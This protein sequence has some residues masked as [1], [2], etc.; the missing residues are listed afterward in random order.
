MRNRLALLVLWLAVPAGPALA[1]DVLPI[2]PQRRSFTPDEL[3]AALRAGGGPAAG[4]PL[5]DLAANAGLLQKIAQSPALRK[6][7]ENLMGNEELRNRLL[8]DPEL[9][10]KFD[11]PQLRAMAERLARQLPKPPPRTGDSPPAGIPP[12]L[13]RPPRPDAP[14]PPA[15]AE[16][17]V[18]GQPPGADPDPVREM[19]EG[20]DPE[21][22]RQELRGL[23]RDEPAP[24][25]GLPEGLSP[26]DPSPAPGG[27]AAADDR[28]GTAANRPPPVRTEAD[29]E[30]ARQRVRQ[31]IRQRRAQ[32]DGDPVQ[33]QAALNDTLNDL[34]GRNANRPERRTDPSR[35][36]EG[37]TRRRGPAAVTPDR[38]DPDGPKPERPEFGRPE[39]NGPVRNMAPVADTGPTGRPRTPA[40]TTEPPAPVPTAG[41][42]TPAAP[43]A[44][45][46]LRTAA[47]RVGSTA[48][49]LATASRGWTDAL[50]S[51]LPAVSVLPALP[52]VSVPRVKVPRV[53]LP[54]FGRDRL[55]RIGSVRPPTARETT[56][57]V[58]ALLLV[59]LIVATGLILWRHDEFLGGGRHGGSRPRR[60]DVAGLAPAEAVRV[61]F[62]NTAQR[63]FGRRVRSNHHRA[64]LD[65]FAAA[66]VPPD[67]AEV[68][69]RLYEQARYAP[70]PDL[71]AADVH[72]AEELRRQVEQSQRRGAS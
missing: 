10:E 12:D 42:R 40:D 11:D 19:L 7:A 52:K 59:G 44:A 26:K 68:V 16:P 43:G 39:R 70:Q 8:N 55:P 14:R 4:D 27:T 15:G 56:R 63:A 32:R 30:A 72:R 66:G 17:Q 28:A 13:P 3:R 51:A 23:R 31:L 67:T 62:E 65:R 50:R 64:V 24:A 25:P 34:R 2:H 35:P 29:R 33:R 18:S 61:L 49:K 58:A 53:P 1:Q 21:Q 5:A 6:V 20:V 45:D 57:G 54:K 69:G 22:L 47:D 37:A 46:R 9:R 60:A 36:G 71:D 48:R 41:P 38:P